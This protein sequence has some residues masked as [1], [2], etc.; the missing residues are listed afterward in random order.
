MPTYQY[1]CLSCKK[2]FEVVISISEYEKGKVKCPD[3]GKG[4]VE[5]QVTGFTVQTSK[6]S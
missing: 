4:R 6:K 5:Q 1:Y 2:S 3:C